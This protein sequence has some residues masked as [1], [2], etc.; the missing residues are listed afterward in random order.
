MVVTGAGIVLLDGDWLLIDSGCVDD[1]F[2]DKGSICGD[3]FCFPFNSYQ[4]YHF[5]QHFGLLHSVSIVLELSY[6]QLRICQL[7]EGD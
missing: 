2:I 6:S 7:F 5:S 4:K 3:F 1:K